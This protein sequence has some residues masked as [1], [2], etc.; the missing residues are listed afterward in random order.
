[1]ISVQTHTGWMVGTVAAMAVLGIGTLSPAVELGEALPVA[2]QS[3]VLVASTSVQTAAIP[4][5]ISPSQ[6]ASPVA[7]RVAA[8]TGGLSHKVGRVAKS[9]RKSAPSHPQEAPLTLEEL[10]EL[11]R[12]LDLASRS[13]WNRELNP[14]H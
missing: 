5:L 13:Y 14:P 12:H 11:E 3:S 7:H 2:K 1:M 6:P 4:P 8:R 10:R 9:T